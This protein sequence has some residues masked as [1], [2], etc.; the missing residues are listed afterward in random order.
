M[1]TLEQIY[2]DINQESSMLGIYT[3]LRNEYIE[4]NRLYWMDEYEG[5][6]MLIRKATAHAIK[7]TT[8]IWRGEMTFG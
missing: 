6:N 2:Y 3:R 7:Y 4:A 8:L 5:Q 1:R